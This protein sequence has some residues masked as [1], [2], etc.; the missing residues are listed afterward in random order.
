[1]LSWVG[2]NKIYSVKFKAIFLA[3][4]CLFLPSFY[5]SAQTAGDAANPTGNQT[6][7]SDGGAAISD[8]REQDSAGNPDEKKIALSSA[9]TNA[10]SNGNTKNSGG[11]N[12]FL[13]FLRMIL[14]LAIVLAI[15]WIIFKLLQKSTGGKSSEDKFLR[16]VSSITVSPGK[17][18]QVVTL[19]DRAFLI[20]VADNS[21]NL[22][23]EI[24][25]P[26]LISAM[27][28]YA[29]RNVGSS[30]PKNFSEVL[31]IFMPKKKGQATKK[32]VF[33]DGAAQQILK[34]LKKQ[35][36]RMNKDE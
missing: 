4:A 23:T 34:S 1:M 5:L 28:L 22:L 9:A 16:K 20:G 14:V 32:N 13:V 24:T 11:A 6:V 7:S 36:D 3:F 35:S 29:D 21:V 25:D 12:T 8:S 27:N 18:V 19:V 17:S 33:E 26:E 10:A 31:E 30:K 2:E 15:I